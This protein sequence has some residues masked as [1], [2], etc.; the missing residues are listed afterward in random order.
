MNAGNSWNIDM[1]K[2]TR[3]LAAPFL[4]LALVGSVVTYECVKPD[5]ASAASVPPAPAGPLDANSVSALTAI[6]QRYG[7]FGGAGHSR[8]GQRHRDFK[9]QKPTA[10]PIRFR[11]ICSSS[12]DKAAHSGAEWPVWTVLRTAHADATTRPAD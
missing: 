8:G 6:D 1:K 7:N 2:W 5:A 9:E 4:A 3:R 10:R 12:S 11:T